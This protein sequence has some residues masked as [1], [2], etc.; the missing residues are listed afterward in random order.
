VAR[1]HGVDMARQAARSM[2]YV[3]HEDPGNDPFA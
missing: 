3:W 1:F 2:E